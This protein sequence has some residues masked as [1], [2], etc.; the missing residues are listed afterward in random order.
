MRFKECDDRRD[1]LRARESSR[2]ERRRK[3]SQ[4]VYH[5]DGRTKEATKM[6]MKVPNA[7]LLEV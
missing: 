4:N 1:V 7:P 5:S 3:C 2:W 6:D